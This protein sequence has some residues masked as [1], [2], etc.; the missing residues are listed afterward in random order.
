MWFVSFFVLS[1]RRHAFDEMPVV[2]KVHWAN[3]KSSK[4]DGSSE[5]SRIKIK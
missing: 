4:T 3:A 5:I 1:R 2:T